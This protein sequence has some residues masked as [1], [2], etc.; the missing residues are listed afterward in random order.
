MPKCLTFPTISSQTLNSNRSPHRLNYKSTHIH[1]LTYCISP[2]SGQVHR[3][4]TD[5]KT[6]SQ[7]FMCHSKISAP[8]SQPLSGPIG[9]LKTE[10]LLLGG[11][12]VSLGFPCL[13]RS[14]FVAVWARCQ[15]QSQVPLP[16]G[17][18][19]CLSAS[20]FHCFS[21]TLNL[22]LSLFF[23]QYVCWQNKSNCLLK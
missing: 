4:K 6:S 22:L 17:T 20:L 15:N 10:I 9:T 2:V 14:S 21:P 13:R 12:Y 3:C 7:A 5:S 1:I 18:E 8:D 19:I 23:S 11:L 16:T